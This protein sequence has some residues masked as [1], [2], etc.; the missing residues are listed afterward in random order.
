MKNDNEN[1]EEKAILSLK[2]QL[3]LVLKKIEQEKIEQGKL[4]RQEEIKKACVA[5]IETKLPKYI[6][7][8][9]TKSS[10][11]YTRGIWFPVTDIL[12]LG[13][14][15]KDLDFLFSFLKTVLNESK[16]LS[17]VRLE[18]N[19]IFLL[20]FKQTPFTSEQ[21]I[22]AFDLVLAQVLPSHRIIWSAV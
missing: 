7:C 17:C 22:T 14:T 6:Y 1:L 18:P 15:G 16:H 5:W 4:L 11:D 10:K 12:S 2:T 21:D 3:E 19:H 9:A 8:L 13:H 20:G